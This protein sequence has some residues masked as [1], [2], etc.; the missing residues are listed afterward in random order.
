[1][2]TAFFAAVLLVLESIAQPAATAQIEPPS[3]PTLP[4]FINKHYFMEKEFFENSCV[5]IV[6]TKVDEKSLYAALDDIISATE[7]GIFYSDFRGRVAY[8]A[9]VKCDAVPKSAFA[10]VAFFPD[11]SGFALVDPRE[12]EAIAKKEEYGPNWYNHLKADLHQNAYAVDWSSLDKGKSF[13]ELVEE[14]GCITQQVNSGR[15]SYGF[16]VLFIG[17]FGTSFVVVYNAK[18]NSPEFS[19]KVVR[20]GLSKCAV[21]MPIMPRP[22][23][24]EERRAM[25][26]IFNR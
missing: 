17:V 22:L 15:Q 16:P 13:E 14:I 24:D 1:M 19:G 7:F 3:Q 9:P 23:N 20:Y 12:I 5:A 2:R 21:E 18:L 10:P 4:E 6:D 11:V 25:A 26:K 8:V